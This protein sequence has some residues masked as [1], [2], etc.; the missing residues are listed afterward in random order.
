MRRRKPHL[1]EGVGSS[2][3]SQITHHIH[4]KELGSLGTKLRKQPVCYPP[5]GAVL[6]AATPAIDQHHEAHL[7][8][9]IVP[10]FHVETLLATVVVL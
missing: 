6:L 1:V 8:I 10:G 3:I 5:R 9:L 7:R 4:T 2:D